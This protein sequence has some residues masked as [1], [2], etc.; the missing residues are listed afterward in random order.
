MAKLRIVRVITYTTEIEY[1]N[2][3]YPDM[4]IEEAR[5]YEYYL[6][7]PEVVEQVVSAMQYDDEDNPQSVF[8]SVFVSTVEIID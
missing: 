8:V 4:T 2:E 6:E 3:M 5:D 7:I 1:N